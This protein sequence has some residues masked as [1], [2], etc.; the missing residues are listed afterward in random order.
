MKFTNKNG[1]LRIYA[2][3][4]S[5][6][7]VGPSGASYLQ[8]LFTNADLTFPLNRPRCAEILNLDRGN[9]DSN[10]SYN[11]GPDDPIMEPLPISFS[12]RID[13]QTYSQKLVSLLS[14]CTEVSGTKIYT[15]KGTSKLKIQQTGVTTVAMADASKIC[16]QVEIKYDG[17]T[18]EGWELREVYFP[19]EQQTVTER[20][21]SI[22]LNMNGL[23]YGAIVTR[24][25]FGAKFGWTSAI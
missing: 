2:K 7:G 14:G 3:V 1:E 20:E 10:M 15:L 21:D 18:D 22:V 16:M 23:I 5:A 11:E 24:A 17:S 19:P 6:Q 8:I 25:A 9:V 4:G 12:G 13:D